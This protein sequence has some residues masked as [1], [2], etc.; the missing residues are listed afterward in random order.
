MTDRPASLV[1]ADRYPLEER[2]C[3]VYTLRCNI[4]CG[5][6]I[7][8]SSPHRREALTLDEALAVLDWGAADGRK[9]VTFSGGEVFLCYDDLLVL[10]AHAHDQGLE[11]DVETNAFWARTPEHARDRLVPLIE[12]GLRGICLSVDAHH[13]EHF[14]LDRQLHAYHVAREQG[15]H[16]ELNFCPSAS[17]EVDAQI[18]R[19]LEALGIRFIDN[20]L[21][22]RGRARDGLT[23]LP[24]LT[25]R[26]LPDC[27]G[28]NTTVHPSG[29]VFACC[30]FEDENE[31][32]RQLPV[33]SG[34][35]RRHRHALDDGPRSSAL[36]QAFYEPGS[37]GYFR[38]L[39]EREPAFAPLRS[40]RF[41]SICDF[42]A[43]ALSDP[44]RREVLRRCTGLPLPSYE[45]VEP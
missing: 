3:I 41:H 8:A 40:R 9:L 31:G 23:R 32:L 20:P 30:E 7:V 38:T 18:R 33:F 22:N 19:T 14:P 11:V 43:A 26:Q 44:E 17:P 28:L 21:L 10:T 29:D 6:C 2:L 39:L 1:I 36:L 15:L 27:D 35:I 13:V 42:C 34:N 5:H 45:E 25:A 24:T 37:P 16:T 4:T 12:R